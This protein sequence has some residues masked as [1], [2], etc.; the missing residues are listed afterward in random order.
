MHI[1]SLLTEASLIIICI[2]LSGF[3]I[4]F[5]CGPQYRKAQ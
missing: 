3:P 4:D 2:V 1:T 5:L